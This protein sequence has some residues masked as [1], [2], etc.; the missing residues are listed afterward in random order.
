MSA[1]PA[2]EPF[3]FGDVFGDIFGDIFRPLT[4][5]TPL[6]NHHVQTYYTSLLCNITA[7]RDP[8]QYDHAI[9]AAVL[10]CDPTK[11]LLDRVRVLEEE[12]RQLKQLLT[13]DNHGTP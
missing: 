10:T 7:P 5:T 6:H 1:A 2:K 11:D 8:V 9:T 13:K 12:V 4:P 3:L